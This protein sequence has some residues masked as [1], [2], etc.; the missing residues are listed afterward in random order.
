MHLYFVFCAKL[1]EG[2]IKIYPK[3]KQQ[4]LIALNIEIFLF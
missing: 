4:N 2:C 1:L 3:I